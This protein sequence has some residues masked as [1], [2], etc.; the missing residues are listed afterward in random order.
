MRTVHDPS[1]VSW[2]RRIADQAYDK[3]VDLAKERGAM[4]GGHHNRN[5]VLPLTE[6]MARHVRRDAGK[7]ALV[8]H[9]NARQVVR[10]PRENRAIVGVQRL[11]RGACVDQQHHEVGAFDRRPRAL[12]ADAL[13][14]IV[15]VA[16]AR[17]VDHGERNAADLDH[18]LDR[19]ARR[20]GDRRHDRRFLARQ[21][22][23]KTRLA[24]V[25]APDQHHRQPLA[26]DLHEIDP[27]EIRT[28]ALLIAFDGDAI[29]PPWQM[30]ELRDRLAG[31]AELVVLESIYGHDAFLKS[32]EAYA[33]LLRHQ[34]LENVR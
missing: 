18:A 17:G 22:I 20:A 23:E 9:D 15:G 4:S 32:S 27:A 30:A 25:G 13:D 33:T 29:A 10:Q 28:P 16:Q 6:D 1:R 12:D 19:I 24:H 7:I 11:R 3:F 26:L 14:R 2:E 8:M 21:L 31:P 5:Y 34:L